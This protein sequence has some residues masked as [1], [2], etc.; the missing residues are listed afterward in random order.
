[1]KYEFFLKFAINANTSTSV[2]ISYILS[3]LSIDY[4]VH[5]ALALLAYYF[6]YFL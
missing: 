5:A 2:L 4:T 3:L 1:M 6:E